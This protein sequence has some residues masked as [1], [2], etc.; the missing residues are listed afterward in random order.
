LDV[1][2]SMPRRSPAPQAVWQL[3][4]YKVRYMENNVVFSW[5]YIKGIILLKHENGNI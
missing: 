5:Y 3:A 4:T 1:A 2:L